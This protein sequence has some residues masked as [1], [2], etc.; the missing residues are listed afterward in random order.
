MDDFILPFFVNL[1]KWL[2]LF[3]IGGA[4]ELLYYI[5]ALPVWIITGGRLPSKDPLKLPKKD[6]RWYALLGLLVLVI[7]AVLAHFSY[8]AMQKEAITVAMAF[9]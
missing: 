8:Q 6:R 7:L 2:G 4:Y 1:F 3:V 9:I 5:G